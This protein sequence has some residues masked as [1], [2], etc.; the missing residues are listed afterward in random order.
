MSTL[1]V[2]TILGESGAERRGLMTYAIICDQK[3]DSDSGGQFTNGA[4]QTREL[5]HTIADPDDIVTIPATNDR[6]TLQA[7]SYLIEAS[8]PAYKV[9]NH[10]A[11]L[12]NETTGTVVQYGKN[13]YSDSTENVADESVV[14]ARV[15]I[16]SETSFKIQH[17]CTTTKPTN[18]YGNTVTGFG[19]VGIFT[20]VK[21]YKEA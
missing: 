21:I 8:A 9:N 17:R 13:A 11:R 18:G 15:T 16:T 14:V 3:A 5:N 10:Q 1:R 20:V 2:D 6:F 4:W 19:G 7:G 12:Y